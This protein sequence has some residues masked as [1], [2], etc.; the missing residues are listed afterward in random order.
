VARAAAT[1]ALS[2]MTKWESSRGTTDLNDFALLDAHC[3]KLSSDGS[4]IV[5]DPVSPA[6]WFLNEAAISALAVVQADPSVAS[7]LVSGLKSCFADTSG[8]EA[9]LLNAAALRGWSYT[10]TAQNIT[11]GTSIGTNNVERVG[12]SVN[13]TEHVTLTET[14][15]PYS[16][17][18]NFGLVSTLPYS[19]LDPYWSINTGAKFHGQSA[20]PCSPFNGADGSANRHLILS[21]NG[22]SIGAR[23]VIPVTD[24]TYA[25][26]CVSTAVVDP[27][28]YTQP[29]AYYDANG[30]VVGPQAN[31]FALTAT[32]L[33]ADPTHAGQWATRTIN[34]VQHW[35]TFSSPV[36]IAG[37]TVYGFVQLY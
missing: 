37:L 12:A 32:S 1:G 9:Y 29:G 36:Y 31:P 25:S 24:C 23:Q 30:N 8:T 21:V 16:E 4:Q 34:G 3:Y 15:N 18:K 5:F 11:L 35:G 10:T 13:G 33:Y 17:D 20:V 2:V 6:G 19:T 22:S 28:P 14:V 7:Y 26:H 27:I